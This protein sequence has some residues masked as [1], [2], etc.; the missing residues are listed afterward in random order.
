ML[1]A[2]FRRLQEWVAPGALTNPVVF[3]YAAKISVWGRWFICAVGILLLVYRPGSWYPHDM[4]YLIIPTTSAVVNGLVHHRILTKRTVSWRWILFLSAADLALITQGIFIG[5]GYQSFMF[6]AYFP[7]LVVIAMVFASVWLTLTWTT[8][9][10]V[11]YTVKDGEK[12][13][14]VGGPIADSGG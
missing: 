1:R 9:A 3:L 7:A 10:A 5:G 14:R 11:V 8:I 6:M 2:G 4:E 12:M 13:Y